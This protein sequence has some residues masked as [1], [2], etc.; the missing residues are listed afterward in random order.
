MAI[1]LNKED[2]RSL[3]PSLQRYMEEEL[4][5]TLSDF[6]TT[7]LLDYIIKE[8]GPYAYNKG[9]E[10]SEAYFRARVEDLSA[11]CYED[12]LTYWT[13]RKK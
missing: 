10:D 11:T 6:K 13:R 7:L 9:V 12:G 4:D 8:I 1:E 3:I 5:Q 2:I